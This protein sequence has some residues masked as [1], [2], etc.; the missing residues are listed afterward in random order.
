[1]CD[2]PSESKT[3]TD[4]LNAPF[5][6]VPESRFKVNATFAVDFGGFVWPVEICNGPGVAFGFTSPLTAGYPS[7]EAPPLE[8]K[9]PTAE[10]EKSPAR[11]YKRSPLLSRMKYPFP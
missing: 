1:M 10:I 2:A 8:S 6:A 3:A 4:V 11:V 7:T 5:T 9:F